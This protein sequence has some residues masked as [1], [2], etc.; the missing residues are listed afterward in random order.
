MKDK[1]IFVTMARSHK[2]GGVFEVVYQLGTA[3]LRNG[4]DIEVTWRDGVEARADRHLFGKMS[5]LEFSTPQV[6]VLKQIGWSPNLLKNLTNRKPSIIHSHGIWMYNSYVVK[7]CKKQN[8]NI[9]TVITPHGMLDHWAVKN[10]RWKK[11]IVGWLFENKNLQAAD[12]IQALNQSEYMSI[13][14][15]GLK[16][17]VAIIPNGIT[18]PMNLKYNRCKSIKTLIFIGR[19]HP[20]KGIAEL[21]EGLHMLNNNN[22]GVM[23]NWKI[24]IAGWDQHGHTE[25]LKGKSSELGLEGIVEFIGPVLGENKEN[26]LCNAD[27]YV[28]TSFS[29]GLPMSV[30]EAWS[31][32]LPV[33]MTDECNLTDGFKNGAAIRVTTEA[34]SIARGLEKLFTM[35]DEERTAMGK[36]GLE[37]VKKSYTWDGIADMTI[38]LYQWLL[39]GGEKP[40]FVL[41]Q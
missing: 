6:P 15:Y 34:Q 25:F 5:L 41:T 29:E 7:E 40:G 37:L 20:K 30:L 3:L 12:C 35:S 38:Q 28:L 2:G 18:L 8:P 9:K 39:E 4:V 17:P 21:L 32:E 13:R 11:K 36:K 26:E 23:K 27:A 19:I 24:R 33:V 1:V 14:Q 22:P 10:S 31:H 16:N